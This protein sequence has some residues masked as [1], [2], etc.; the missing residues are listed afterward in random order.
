M[1]LKMMKTKILIFTC[2]FYSVFSLF[3]I[4]P[5]NQIYPK[6]QSSTYGKQHRHVKRVWNMGYQDAQKDFSE[7][8]DHWLFHKRNPGG[9]K[10]I[11]ELT[12]RMGATSPIPLQLV[13]IILVNLGII[14]Q[15]KW[16]SEFFK[17]DIFPVVGCLF[18]LGTHFLMYFGSNIHQHTYNFSFFSFCLL[19]VTRY[20]NTK[21]NK[22]LVY[23]FLSY[24]F[25]C[26]NYYMAWVATYVMMVGTLYAGGVKLISW[27]NLILGIPPVLTVIFLLWNVS[28]AHNGL[29]NGLKSIEKIAKVRVYGE[30]DPEMHEKQPE[31]TA[32]SWVRYPLTV[33]SRIERY[34]YLPGLVFILLA[35]ILNRLRKKNNSTLNYKYFYWIAPAALSWYMLM[36]Q[37]VDV[38][39]EVGHYSY[40]LWMIMFGYFF[41]EILDYMKKN[42]KYTVKHF[43]KY[44]WPL[45]IVYGGYGFLYFNVFHLLINIKNVFND[46][47]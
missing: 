44:T 24:L 5:V 27:K 16:L 3:L 36:F 8:K 29:S 15:F 37:H 39:Q 19:A 35:W 9:F 14:A 7:V 4:Q 43:V 30:V 32:K 33:A 17:E 45:L 10:F 12:A 46:S 20:N 41:Y 28:Y 21:Q 22:Y 42:N 1:N 40:F 11:A 6:Y 25:L 18:L 34:F 26:Q 47:F 13:L 38:H 23:A 31:M 2:L